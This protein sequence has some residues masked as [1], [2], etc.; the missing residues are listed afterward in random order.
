MSVG[1][2]VRHLLVLVKAGGNFHAAGRCDSLVFSIKRLSENKQVQYFLAQ[3]YTVGGGS[4][5]IAY[6]NA[7]FS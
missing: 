5:S 3:G 4:I 1:F 2:L 7:I 6:V